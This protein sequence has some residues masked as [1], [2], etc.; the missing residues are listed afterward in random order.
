MIYISLTL[1]I[2]VFLLTANE[3]LQ[4]QLIILTNRRAMKENQFSN[5]ENARE[6]RIGYI[7]GAVLFLVMM[8]MAMLA[9]TAFLILFDKMLK[10]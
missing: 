2:T 4:H 3:V 6:A 7:K 9:I 1:L 10:P 5:R 8:A